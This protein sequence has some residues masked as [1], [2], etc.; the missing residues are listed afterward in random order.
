MLTPLI[1]QP[2]KFKVPDVMPS[3]LRPLLR[4]A[5]E[6]LDLLLAIQE[7]TH[8]LGFRDFTHGV[9]LSP[10]PDADSHSYV[11]TTC[12]LE[13]TRIYDQK[14]YIEIDPRILH[15]IESTLPLVWD[16]Q[17]LRGRSPMTDIFLDDAA[18]YGVC[19]GVSVS[20]RDSHLRGGMSTLSSP[21]PVIQRSMRLRIAERMSDIITF[22]RYFHE[23]II[24]AI[25]EQ[26]LPP[27]ARGAPLSPRERQCLQM[28]A[29]GLTSRDICRKLGITERT[30]NFH[31][32]NLLAKM[33]ALNR[34]EA[35]AR[36]V[37]KG[38]VHVES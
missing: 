33:N 37:A 27:L 12:P 18:R 19:S 1:L 36:A 6:G 34:K 29:Q 4:A 22:G 21:E 32:G 38:I 35:V 20:I 2:M 30:V 14:S 7:V 24:A 11:F 10:H 25:L 28:S 13:W 3:F 9:S 5:A 16:Q 23:L 26:K 17:S 15:G 8:S 31:F